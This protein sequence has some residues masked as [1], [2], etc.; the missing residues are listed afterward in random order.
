ME[1]D[2]INDTEKSFLSGKKRMDKL[3]VLMK[4]AG[5]SV[6]EYFPDSDRMVLYNE[7]LEEEKGIMPF[8]GQLG[9]ICTIHPEDV[10][11]MREFLLGQTLGTVE[12]KLLK[13]GHYK[14]VL[15]DALQKEEGDQSVI[16]CI[17]DITEIRKR[18][19]L[20]EDQAR[21][22]SM[23]GLYNHDT[24][25]LLVNEYLR[26]K[27]M[28]ASS[29]LL[30]L[31]VDHFKNVNDVYGHLFGDEVLIGF[32][33]FLQSF[34]RKE[35]ILIRTGGDE[36]AVFLKEISREALEKKVSEL[37]K[38]VGKLTF[39]K[40]DFVMS[41][42]VGVCFLPG[43]LGDYSYEQLLEHADLALYRAKIAGRNQYAVGEKLI[44]L[45]TGNKGET[46]VKLLMDE[47]MEKREFEIYFQ[48]KISLHN[49]KIVGAEALVRWRRPDGI[50][51]R[52]EHFLPFYEKNG[53][54]VELDFYVFEQVAAFLEKTKR[55]GITPVPVSVNV[56]ALHAEDPQ[57]TRRYLEILEKYKVDPGMLEME[58]K[59]TDTIR[60]ENIKDLLRSLQ[61]AGFR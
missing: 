43:G 45:D 17:R 37:V 12:L 41:C 46:A 3:K 6:F 51:V 10:Q 52:P 26:E 36:F 42:S 2:R 40:R 22:D 9:Q 29:G 27:R 20:L 60:Y 55:S 58:L 44:P 13:K 4:Y 25:K 32:S 15:L 50:V 19:E 31:D 1:K 48:P 28:D 38:R 35:D 39:S 57:T 5:I 7:Q 53:K 18:E 34:F 11:K 16:G 33:G 47:T 8:L 54:I 24:G 56:S 14:R 49:Y 30:M 61:E 23:T 59:E 21:R